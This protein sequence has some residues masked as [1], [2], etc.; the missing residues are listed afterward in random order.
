MEILLSLVIFYELIFQPFVTYLAIA[1]I[2]DHGRL[3]L[4]FIATTSSASIQD[5]AI[6]PTSRIDFLSVAV[7]LFKRAPV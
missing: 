1:F 4:D 2:F 6:F 7:K 3:R 5:S